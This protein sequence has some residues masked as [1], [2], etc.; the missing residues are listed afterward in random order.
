MLFLTTLA[1]L[2]PYTSS[3]RVFLQGRRVLGASQVFTILRLQQYYYELLLL[4]QCAWI[5]KQNI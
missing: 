3:S 5:R 2:K 1:F 4:Y